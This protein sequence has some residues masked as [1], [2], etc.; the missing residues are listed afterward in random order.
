MRPGE[1]QLQAKHR[2]GPGVHTCQG[3]R[4][5]DYT[6]H[7]VETSEGSHL[8]SA[9]ELSSEEHGEERNSGYKKRTMFI[10]WR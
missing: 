8:T 10:F 9:A 1:T 2:A 5:V 3:E 4:L 6:G 7:R